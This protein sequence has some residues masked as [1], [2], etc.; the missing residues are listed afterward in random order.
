MRIDTDRLDVLDGRAGNAYRKQGSAVVEFALAFLVLMAFLFGVIDFCRAVYTYEFVTYAARTGA[1]WAMVRGNQCYLANPASWCEPAGSAS[2]GATSADVQTFVQSLHLPGIA[3]HLISVTAK[4]PA[5]G[6]TCV[7][8]NGSN[9]PGC[10]VQ[11]IVQY[12]YSSQIPFV[13]IKIITLTADS[14]MVISQ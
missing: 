13:R 1:R 14:Q 7:S 9:S 11:V 5:T 10:P 6:S 2:T 3:G 12:P 8:A 4:W